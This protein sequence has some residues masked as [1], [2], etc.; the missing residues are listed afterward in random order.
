VTCTP[1]PIRWT[2]DIPFEDEPELVDI[3]VSAAQDI[4][5]G[6]SGR[7]YGIC[8]VTEEYRPPCDDCLPPYVGDFGPGVE[9]QLG[10][11]RRDCCKIHLMRQ[12]V[13]AITSV[14]V[15]GVALDDD[16]FTLDLNVLR[17]VG[18]CWPCG[19]GCDEAPVKVSYEW[20]LDVPPLGELAMGEV[21]CEI[22]RAMK[23]L[24][25]RLPANAVRIDRQGV[26][27]ELEPLQSLYAMNRLGLPIA[28]QF[29]RAVNPHRLQSRSVVYSPDLARRSR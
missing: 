5:F 13:R 4:L 24:D 27:I 8:E 12:P 7:R 16:E 14:E 2:C 20:G 25:C 17:R 10:R 19:D 6:L 26:S 9:Y 11:Q 3:A 1:W 28:D 18:A 23:R 29:L 21:A 15:D 22:L